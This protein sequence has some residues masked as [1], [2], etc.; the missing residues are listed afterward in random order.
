MNLLQFILQEFQGRL[1]VAILAGSLS[2]G[3]NALLLALI[4]Y[5]ISSKTDFNPLII[6]KFIGLIL[7]TSL[8]GIISQFLL[9][10]ISQDAVYRLRLRLSRQILSSPLQHLEK[11]GPQRLLATLADDTLSISTSV[12]NIP[13]LCIN[14]AIIISCLVYLCWLNWIVFV[15]VAFFLALII[16]TVHFFIDRA[17][18]YMKLAREEQDQLFKHFRAITDGTKELKLHICRRQAFLTQEIE[19]T[20][21]SLRDYRVT[22]L[23]ILAFATT[24]GEILF[25][26]ILGLLVLGLPRI[27]TV[28][29]DI[30]SGYVLTITYLVRPLEGILQ[31]L[32]TLTQG[33]V[34]LHKVNTLGL[35]LASCAE[36]EVTHQYTE[37]PL[38]KDCL[39][40]SQIF[41]TYNHEQ[42]ERHFT[43][44][45][46]DL[47]IYSGEMT[48]I[49]GGNGSGKSTLAKLI[50]GLYIPDKGNIFIDGQ[51]VTSHNRE[52]YRQLFTAVF[53][54]FYLFERLLGINL[55]N[56]E[57]Q[58]QDYLTRLQLNPKVQIQNGL[59]STLALS[60]GQRKR[61]AL[62]TAYLEDR[63]IYLFDEWAADQDPFFRDIFYHQLLP[64]LKN[65]GKTIIVI[66]HDDNYFHIADKVVKLDYGKIVEI[67]KNINT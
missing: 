1:A 10:N 44:G 3:F 52:G 63:P 9:I 31:I 55:D 16:V 17:S 29:N 19:T 27:A 61:L 8:T 51:K 60:Q 21:A 26:V 43:L 35:S 12:F 49:I 18:R 46:I 64:Q 23:Q 54:D 20:T 45:P 41:H 6:W 25:F 36:P 11:L 30:L 34:A 32:P 37:V 48:F 59:F 2:G 65:Q 39:E 53:S 58:I 38:F 15:A 42:E 62:L 22:A 40:L 47:S 66:S 13:F 14:V 33:S 5:V 24:T 7:I 56:L 57:Q 4:N 28:S 50:T 67:S